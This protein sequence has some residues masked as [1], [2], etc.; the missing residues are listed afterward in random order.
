[1]PGKAAAEAAT[2]AAAESAHVATAKT[3]GMAA[4]CMLRESGRRKGEQG[5]EHQQAHKPRT[6]DPMAH[7]LN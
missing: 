3:A 1:V 2:V 7:R 6:G 4:R 5:S